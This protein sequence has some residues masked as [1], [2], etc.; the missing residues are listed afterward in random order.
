MS[1][2][3]HPLG[4]CFVFIKKRPCSNP[5]SF[6]GLAVDAPV[7]DVEKL[8]TPVTTDQNAPCPLN[9]VYN[10]EVHY[11]SVTLNH[12]DYTVYTAV[13]SRGT[14]FQG[15]IVRGDLMPTLGSM[16]IGI[17]DFQLFL[18][19]VPANLDVLPKAVSPRARVYFS[20]VPIKIRETTQNNRILEATIVFQCV[21]VYQVLTEGAIETEMTNTGSGGGGGSHGMEV[22]GG[23][24]F[25]S[26]I[27]QSI[28][29]AL[30]GGPNPGGFAGKIETTF[31]T[32]SVPPI[33]A[34]NCPTSPL[35]SS[36][37]S[38]LTTGER[39]FLLYS[40]IPM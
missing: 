37:G 27:A 10:G 22:Q 26:G 23:D 33:S 18:V 36:N 13:R 40:E 38:P 32:D 19:W 39:V 21:P 17:E 15:G 31:I 16:T 3:M 24:G 11:V 5:V 30:N 2:V 14:I 35:A 29:N 9:F 34:L 8:H 7:V 4:P 28:Q 20:A 6:L 12:I 25:F 1:S